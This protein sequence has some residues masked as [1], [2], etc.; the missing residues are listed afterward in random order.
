M[1]EFDLIRTFF[2]RP[3]RQP[4]VALGIGD[5][6]ALLAPQPGCELA[7]STDMLVADRHFF[8]DVDPAALGW[9]ALAV[10]L[11]DLAAMGAEP[12]GF[13]LALALPEERDAW[14]T[15]FTRGLFACADAHA[16]PLIGGDTTRGPLNLAIT[17]FGSLPAGQAVRRVGANAGDEVWV[18]GWPGRAALGL[19]LRAQEHGLAGPLADAA[20]LA[21]GGVPPVPADITG[22]LDHAD[23]VEAIAALER[24]VPRLALGQALRGVASAMLDVSDGLL[25]DLAHL[26]AASGGLGADLALAELPVAPL[27]RS[28]PEAVRLAA[29]LAG[30]DDYE[31]CFTAPP[32]RRAAVEQA[33][34][35]AGTRVTRIGVLRTAPGVVVRDAAGHPVPDLDRF[36]GYDHFARP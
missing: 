7:V 14:L 11:S 24:P 31:L 15:E 10:N 21:G 1:G 16:C 32:Q 26:L 36:K 18:S 2:Q 3:Q 17:I 22:L 20:T 29:I 4:G 12:L 35:T 30:G 33:A 19:Q 34:R 25:A 5:D 6:C 28:Q 13:V 8:I 23:R 9:K 27:L